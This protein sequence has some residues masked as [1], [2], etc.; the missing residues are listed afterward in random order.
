METGGFIPLSEPW[1]AGN[2]KKYVTDCLDSGWISGAGAYVS[3]FEADF[4]SFTGAAAAAA[5]VNG[6]AAIHLA[7]LTA[8]LG[9]G[10]GVFVPALT[11]IASVNAVV[12]TGARPVFIDSDDDCLG[13]SP[14]SLSSY[15]E[16]RCVFSDAVLKDRSSGLKITAVLPV[17]LMGFACRL[18]ELSEICAKYNL[19]MIEDAAEA[20]GVLYKGKHT[21]LFGAAGCFSF[22]GNKTLTTGGGGMAVS[23]DSALV[24]KIKH[25]STQ[26]KTDEIRYT[27]D[28]TGY[29]YRM[30]N[31]HAAIG[32]AQLERLGAV[33]ERKKQ[34]FGVYEREFDG[35]KDFSLARPPE[36][37]R[38]NHWMALLRMAP[39]KRGPFMSHMASAKIQ[40]RPLW[41][42][43]HRHPMHSAA[44]RGDLSNAEK[45]HAE[46]VS[47]P[48]FQRMDGDDVGRVVSAVKSFF[49][50]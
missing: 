26:A 36:W 25:L 28:A 43:N 10:N 38:S 13:L 29:N 14:D 24:K 19:V 34:I 37:T 30:S 6:T 21:G 7:L 44:P 20:L 11:F 16:K 17:H 49:K 3:K 23:N 45:I 12:Y 41:E 50:K 31:V 40:T 47:I 8:G 9:P 35:A 48:C 33:L 22:N 32:V 2:E 15:I 39:E 42:L 46:A 27:H 4:A 18:N 5:V 1:L